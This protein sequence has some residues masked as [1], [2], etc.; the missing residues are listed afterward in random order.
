MYQAQAENKCLGHKSSH[1][2]QAATETLEAF[3]L[4]QPMPSNNEA[5]DVTTRRRRANHEEIRMREH[6]IEESNKVQFGPAE[7]NAWGICASRMRV[8]GSGAANTPKFFQLFPGELPPID[9]QH[10]GMAFPT[11]KN[12]LGR[13]HIP[14]AIVRH[15]MDVVEYFGRY[16]SLCDL[17][18]RKAIKEA[19][20]RAL[21]LETIKD[22][23]WKFINIGDF[24]ATKPLAEF[25]TTSE[26]RVEGLGEDF[27]QRYL[28]IQ[29]VVAHNID[30][31]DKLL[32]GELLTL[33]RIMKGR[34]KTGKFRHHVV[35]PVLLFS[36]MGPQHARIL[37]S[38]YNG[39]ELIVKYSELFD[40]TI[41][42]DETMQLFA[43][44]FESR[45][46]GNTEDDDENQ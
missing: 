9:E 12:E 46:I 4:V 5:D 43:R 27:K 16:F 15:V 26:W 34:L 29:C 8:D 30:G 28:H 11:F 20:P 18:K 39:H 32:R 3:Y 33:T 10:I 38:Y 41:R 36:Y 25:N 40:L 2:G 17:A 31:D 44:W 37:E 19:M 1:I 35:A 45:P 6:Y 14:G 24:H 42:N 23:S 21:A 7:L 22:E 13:Q